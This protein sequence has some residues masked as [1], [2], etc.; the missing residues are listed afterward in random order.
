MRRLG[1]AP[2]I[3]AAVKA[4][5]LSLTAW[6][7]GI[8]GFM[9]VADFWIFGRLLGVELK[10]DTAEFWSTMQVAMIFGFLTSYPAN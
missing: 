9:A 6:Q 3:W 10:V 1:V 2:G 7:V 4:D 5:T 8:Y